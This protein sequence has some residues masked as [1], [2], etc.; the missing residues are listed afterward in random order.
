MVVILFDVLKFDWIFDDEH[1]V[2]II[3]SVGNIS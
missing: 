1:I 2:E 3:N